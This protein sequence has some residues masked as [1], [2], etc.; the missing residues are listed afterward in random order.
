MYERH[1][2]DSKTEIDQL[3][4]WL[5][6]T[7]M[8]SA[9]YRERVLGI[10]GTGLA[11]LPIQALRRRDPRASGGRLGAYVEHPRRIC[12]G[13][14][15]NPDQSASEQMSR[16][17]RRPCLN[18]CSPRFR[19]LQSPDTAGARSI[20]RILLF[21]VAPLPAL[22]RRLGMTSRYLKS[23]FAP[24]PKSH[25]NHT[26]SGFTPA[27]G[28]APWLCGAEGRIMKRAHYLSGRAYQ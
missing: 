12:D 11:L 2:E 3:R 10:A 19:A 8:A 17:L 15:C 4:F 16:R 25:A 5:Q 18:D 13:R 28:P 20:M 22:M 6:S 21:S 14:E 1:E 23:Q 9:T 27:C 24:R 26:R 7:P